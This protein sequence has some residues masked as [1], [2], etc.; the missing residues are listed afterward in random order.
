VVATIH[1]Q[2]D[3]DWM[4]AYSAEREPQ[5]T[6]RFTIFLRSAGHAYHHVGQIIYL[7]R[8]LTQQEGPP[9]R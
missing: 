9:R 1:K 6:N 4:A 7:C 8:E 2:K 3:A 5:A